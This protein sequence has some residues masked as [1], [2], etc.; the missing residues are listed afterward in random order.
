M[1]STAHNRIYTPDLQPKNGRILA[2]ERIFD[3][4]NAAFLVDGV[5]PL[6]DAYRRRTI[7]FT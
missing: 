6:N 3:L 4:V 2:R 7:Y 1:R 5:P